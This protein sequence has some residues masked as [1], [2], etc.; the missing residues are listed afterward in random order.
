MKYVSVDNI[1]KI[2]RGWAEQ[3]FVKINEEETSFLIHIIV[4]DAVEIDTTK[5]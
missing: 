1:E 3:Q 5:E 2:I 4:E